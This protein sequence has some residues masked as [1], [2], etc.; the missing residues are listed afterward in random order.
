VCEIASPKVGVGF[1]TR[2]PPVRQHLLFLRATMHPAWL[3]PEILEMILDTISLP[4]SFKLDSLPKLYPTWAN[5]ALT[6]KAFR[7]PALDRLWHHPLSIVYLIKSTPQD[8]WYE[9]ESILVCAQLLNI[10]LHPSL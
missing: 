7:G 1:F 9:Q 3:V 4:V 5:L 8:L 10:W 6:C 2:H